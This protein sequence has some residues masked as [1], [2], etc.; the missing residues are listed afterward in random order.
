MSNDIDHEIHLRVFKDRSEIHL[1]TNEYL[2]F[3]EGTTSPKA[4]SRYKLILEALESGYLESMIDLCISH[5]EQLEI[6]SLNENQHSLIDEISSSV[7][8]NYG[9]GIVGLAFL[10]LV[11][12]AITPTQSIRL[13]KSST[14]N[15]KF[16]WVEGVSMR[17]LDK[18]YITPVLR[19][20]DLLK[21]NADGFMMTRTLAENYPY[22]RFYK[23]QLQ[24]AR[25][26]WLNLVEELEHPDSK[27]NALAGLQLLTSKLLNHAEKFEALTVSA[28]K[29]NYCLIENHTLTI[30]TV[31]ILMEKHR[32]ESN[33]AARIMEVSMH[34][35]MQALQDNQQLDYTLKPLSQMRSANKKHGNIGDVEL[36]NHRLIV[37]SWD[38]KYGKTYLREELNELEDKLSF[39]E[40]VEIAG[41]VTSDEPDMRHEIVTSIKDISENFGI[42]IKVLSFQNWIYFQLEKFGITEHADLSAISNAW[43]ISYVETLSLKRRHLAPIDEPCQQWLESWSDILTSYSER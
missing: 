36:L 12:K 14:N 8:S 42:T 25:F 18:Q 38:A 4:K 28:I 7:T 6:E 37:E 30:A 1:N 39:H 20:Y 27:M 22:S 23:A 40:S 41:F 35:F 24:G 15:S 31:V 33:Y 2:S 29:A 11:I 19:K 9:R 34:S 5:P 3:V 43:L 26:A 13:H 10:Q 16:S 21:L 17:S 32:T